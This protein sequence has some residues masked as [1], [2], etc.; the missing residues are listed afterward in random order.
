MGYYEKC[1]G[2]TDV[3]AYN[4]LQLSVTN[5]PFNV[6]FGLCLPKECNQD[7]MNSAGNAISKSLSSAVNK[8]ATTLNIEVLLKY[9]V[10]VQ[11]IFTQPDVWNE[12][13]SNN[14]S[15]AAYIVGGF[16][17]VFCRNLSCIFSFRSS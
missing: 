5:L 17:A 7:M 4:V 9:D 15:T 2:L 10:G 13:Q 3:A 16:L 12:T 11:F 14:N 6:R 1:I 8:L